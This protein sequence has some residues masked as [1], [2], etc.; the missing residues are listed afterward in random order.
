MQEAGITPK[1]LPL[2]KLKKSNK[3]QNQNNLLKGE[4]ASICL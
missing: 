1:K 3:I 2:K 4:R